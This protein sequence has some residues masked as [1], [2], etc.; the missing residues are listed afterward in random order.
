MLELIIV[1]ITASILLAIIEASWKKLKG[2][3]KKRIDKIKK[4]RKHKKIMNL[5][6]FYPK[7]PEEEIIYYF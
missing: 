2:F 5:L 7:A 3:V 4:N 6:L 1:S